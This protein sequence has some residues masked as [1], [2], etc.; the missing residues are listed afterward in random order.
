MQPSL[1]WD[2]GRI[3]NLS[4][5]MG[6]ISF[7]VL[8]CSA[9]VSIYTPG[10]SAA[11]TIIGYK[12]SFLFTAVRTGRICRSSSAEGRACLRSSQSRAALLHL[13][14]EIHSK[15]RRR[16]GSLL[17]E[18]C[19]LSVFLPS[20]RPNLLDRRCHTGSPGG[21]LKLSSFASL[22]NVHSPEAWLSSL[23]TPLHLQCI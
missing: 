17:N 7:Q 23:L 16:L 9:A 19:R 4:V 13:H 20:G 6:V 15:K 14:S 11:S 8:V 18:A 5:H 22:R 3:R 21:V 12:R 1:Q 2:T 10:S